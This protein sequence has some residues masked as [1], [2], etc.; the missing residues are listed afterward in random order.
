MLALIPFILLTDGCQP[1]PT[2][3]PPPARPPVVI[4]S[5]SP[6]S[7][8]RSQPTEQPTAA[9]PAEADVIE[10]N[11]DNFE[12]EV[13]KAKTLVVV[14]F[15]AEWCGPCK[16]LKPI[17]NELATEYAGRVKFAS[18]DT[19]DNMALSRQYEARAIP[20]LIIFRDGGEINRVVGLVPKDAL[21]SELDRLLAP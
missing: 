3:P 7:P 1:R 4:P 18:L 16:V 2:E 9:Q 17:L 19:D 12:Q 11:S 20:L 10:V 5:S 21:K 14:D 15:W 8:A 6:S 13:L